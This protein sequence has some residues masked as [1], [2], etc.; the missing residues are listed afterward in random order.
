MSEQHYGI[1]AMT[2]DEKAFMDRGPEALFEIIM[3]LRAKESANVHELAV[4]EA[5]REAV[6]GRP[7]SD[8]FESFEIVRMAQDLHDTINMLRAELAASREECERL[9]KALDRTC[10]CYQMH[11]DY[12]RLG[13]KA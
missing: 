7:V 5:L 6:F 3:A 13:D 10:D 8:F 11:D 1:E 4:G 12:C 9:R 2:P